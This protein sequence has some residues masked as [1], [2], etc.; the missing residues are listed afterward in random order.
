MKPKYRHTGG[1]S[2][3]DRSGWRLGP[4]DPPVSL[5][6]GAD[7]TVIAAVRKGILVRVEAI[8]DAVKPDHTEHDDR[9]LLKAIMR[10]AIDNGV[11]SLTKTGKPQLDYLREEM[12]VE[13]GDPMY[14][15]TA[16]RDKLF[17]EISG[18]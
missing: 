3:I 17:E 15:S 7:A 8:E 12:K 13:G 5:P 6:K 1:P 9:E 10:V 18:K 2:V 4:G 16:I 11:E 14:V